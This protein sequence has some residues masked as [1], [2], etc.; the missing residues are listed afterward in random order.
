V[1]LA[2]GFQEAQAVMDEGIRQSIRQDIGGDEQRIHSVKT[3]FGKITFKH[4]LLPVWLSAYRFREKVFRILI[5][6]RTG[7]V[8]GER[9]YSPWKIAG[10]VAAV[11]V[12][13]AIIVAISSLNR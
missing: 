2:D 9:P 6:A 3:Q 4:L 11:L 8:Q 13:V 1:D 5:N 10:A 12:I 7:E